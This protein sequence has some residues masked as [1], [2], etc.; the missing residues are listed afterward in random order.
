MQGLLGV[1]E[2]LPLTSAAG[3]VWREECC[4][5]GALPVDLFFLK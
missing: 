2:K 3:R 1:Y 5:A 4:G